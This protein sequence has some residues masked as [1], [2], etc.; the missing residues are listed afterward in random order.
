MLK[1][2]D[3]ER[4]LWGE[5]DQAQINQYSGYMQEI[6]GVRHELQTLQEH[7]SSERVTQETILSQLRQSLVAQNAQP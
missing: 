2:N 7:I 4:R 1:L 6:N 5:L 3:F